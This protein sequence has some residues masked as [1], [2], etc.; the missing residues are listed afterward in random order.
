MH[1]R[2]RR[3]AGI[4]LVGEIVGIARE[5]IH[6]VHVRT[7]RPRHEPPHRKVLVMLAGQAGALGV[8]LR[9]GGR[10]RDGFGLVH[11]G[12]GRHYSQVS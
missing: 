4:T 1:P 6:S 9:Q 2:L 10:P 11:H 12:F 8:G 7:H 3:T 5:G